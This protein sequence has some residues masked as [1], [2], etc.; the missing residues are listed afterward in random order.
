MA[1]SVVGRLCG[2]GIRNLPLFLRAVLVFGMAM[3]AEAL[4][5]TLHTGSSMGAGGRFVKVVEFACIFWGVLQMKR[6]AEGGE[7]LAE[8]DMEHPVDTTHMYRDLKEHGEHLN[9]I[10]TGMAKAVAGSVKGERFKTGLIQQLP[11]DL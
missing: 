8:G 11:P 9:S 2:A 4:A 6:L 7:R 1:L 10:Q 3:M 5:G